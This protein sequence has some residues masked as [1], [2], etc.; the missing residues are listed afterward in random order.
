MEHGVPAEGS[1]VRSRIRPWLTGKA[2]TRGGA[3]RP[4]CSST[5]FNKL[6]LGPG[7][8]GSMD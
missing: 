1:G 8:C 4:T 6:S 5:S 2:L 7:R 3:Q